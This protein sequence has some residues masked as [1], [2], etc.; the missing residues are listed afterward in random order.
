MRYLIVLILT[1]LVQSAAAQNWEDRRVFNPGARTSLRIISSTD[2]A[3]FASL[4]DAFVAAEPDVSV[5]YLVTGTTDLNQR[6][7][8]APQSFDITIS[9][10]MDLQLKLTNDGYAL[11]LDDIAHPGW[12]QWRQSLFGFT[13][14]PAVI[15]LNRA[16]FKGQPIPRSRQALIEALRARPEAFR[17]RVGTY[18]VRQSGLGYLFATQDSRASETFW[19]LMEVMGGLDARLYCCS[20]EMI[21]DLTTGRIVVAYNVL[22]SYA[23]ARAAHHDHIEIVMPS[24]FP[25]TMMRTA[26]V[27]RRTKNPQTARRFLAHLVAYQST[28][29]E[30]APA[31]PPLQGSEK[32][33][34]RGT[35]ALEPALMTYL[36]RL[37]RTRFLAEWENALIQK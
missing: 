35:I 19:R 17:D 22:G 27:S 3:F 2:T 9:S 12:A 23:A 32:G 15:V 25:T 34:I 5:E 30:E 14:E 10:A 8:D 18:D 7:R 31:L 37:K 29:T 21:N 33:A 28:E 4:I 26:L 6:F 24:D 36:D 1:L 16:A 11:Q 13:S 20:G